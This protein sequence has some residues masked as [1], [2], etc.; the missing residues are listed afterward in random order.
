MADIWRIYGRHDRIMAVVCLKCVVL[1]AQCVAFASCRGGGIAIRPMAEFRC[2]G[3]SE[4]LSFGIDGSPLA[5]GWECGE[6]CGFALCANLGTRLPAGLSLRQAQG[7]SLS[8][9][10]PCGRGLSPA[11]AGFGGFHF[12]KSGCAAGA[13]R[14]LSS[15]HSPGYSRRR[16][17]AEGDW[18]RGGA[19][20]WRASA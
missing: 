5:T 17:V 1:F 8:V 20:Y 12:V 2:F 11:G 13:A 7:R 3:V 10:R 6:R 18:P 14:T 4:F 9:P 15:L 19:S 16:G